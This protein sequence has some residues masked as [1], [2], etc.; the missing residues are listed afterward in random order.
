MSRAYVANFFVHVH[1]LG[2]ATELRVRYPGLWYTRTSY[3]N[4]T[5]LYGMVLLRL[6][7]VHPKLC[8]PSEYRVSTKR[9]ASL[10][11][12]GSIQT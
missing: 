6:D 12:N 7:L 3:A 5:Y 11:Q 4:H 9:I 2:Y 1:A 10:S 8:E